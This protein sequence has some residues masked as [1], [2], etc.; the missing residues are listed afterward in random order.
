VGRAVEDVFDNFP[1]SLDRRVPIAPGGIG[2]AE[3][4]DGRRE[5]GLELNG[6]F[7]MLDGLIVALR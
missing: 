3:T 1:I 4:V 7:K 5:I 6:L 2:V